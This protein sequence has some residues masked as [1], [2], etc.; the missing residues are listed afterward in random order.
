MN[1]GLESKVCLV[2][3][4]SR[5]IGRACALRLAAD[6]FQV[7]I[8]YHS[9]G[10]KAEEVVREIEARGGTAKCFQADVS[11]SA[12]VEKLFS[13]CKKEFGRL[14]VLVNNAGSGR[15]TYLMML[16]DEMIDESLDLNV[17]GVFYCSR[18]AVMPMMPKRQGKIIHISSVSALKGF[19]AMSVYAAGK[20]GI[21]AMTRVMARELAPYGITVNAVAPGFIDTDI[22]QERPE[23]A[24]K[25]DL[26]LIPLK[27]FGTAEEV[28]GLVSYLAGP[29]SGYITG[30]V[31][32]V[33]GGLSC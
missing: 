22:L 31:L 15:S 24:R 27:R 9:N 23:K 10:E 26:E 6:G 5:G 18:A 25:E 1:D 11:K 8:N 20:G 30:Q 3:G 28:A 4:G 2:T 17:K 33:D 14:D 29:E 7:L 13:F 21:N 32:V 12:E 19:G 16:S